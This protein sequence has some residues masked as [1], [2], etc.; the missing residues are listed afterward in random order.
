MRAPLVCCD[1]AGGGTDPVATSI[2]DTISN[3]LADAVAA[4]APSV[5]QV[6]GRR[7]PA[8][9]VVHA[10]D[11]VVT[12]ARALGRDDGLR[13]RRAGAGARRPWESRQ[14]AGRARRTARGGAGTLM[15][16]QRDGERRYRVDHRRSAGD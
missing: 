12:T 4:A 10:S 11:V 8:S 2:L 5:V 13:V 9:G 14:R 3:E 6:I 16:Q 7:R 1:D 15:E